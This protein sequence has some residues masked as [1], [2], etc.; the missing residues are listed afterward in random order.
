MDGIDDLR[1]EYG[2]QY[3]NNNGNI[4][5]IVRHGNEFG[6]S[7]SSGLLIVNVPTIQ[8]PLKSFMEIWRARSSIL[9]SVRESEFLFARSERFLFIATHIPGLDVYADYEQAAETAYNRLFSIMD[10]LHYPKIVRAWNYIG[11]IVDRDAADTEIY[12]SFVAG[13]ATAFHRRGIGSTQ[14]PAATGIG[15]NRSGIS[16]ILICATEE[17][18]IVPVDNPAQT[19]AYDYPSQYGKTAPTFSRAAIQCPGEIGSKNSRMVY[20]SGTA[21]IVGHQTVHP[22]DASAQAKT[23]IDNIATL[24]SNGNL[25]SYGLRTGY[26]PS[27]V[28]HLKVYVKSLD[29]LDSIRAAIETAFPSADIRYLNVD[30]CRPDLLLEIEGTIYDD[31]SDSNHE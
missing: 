16:I 13:R 12:R 2:S 11:G 10:D 4:L 28:D 3:P 31:G 8:P 17:M 25:S 27:N 1:I 23:T 21:S 7:L 30:I 15:A 24:V 5:G 20:I 22:G 14:L 9:E 18:T 6:C 26:T 29:A 19:A